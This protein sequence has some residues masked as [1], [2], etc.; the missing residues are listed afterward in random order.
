MK[1]EPDAHF[2]EFPQPVPYARAVAIQHALVEKR[3]A[4]EIPD[5]FLLLEHPPV[6]T[7]GRRGRRNFLLASEEQLLQEGIT[8]EPSERGGDVTWHGPGQ[9]VLYPI[10]KLGP[11]EM[12]THGY[13]HA[14]E[15][16]AIRTAA[17]FG[18]G[19][20]R[21][22]GMAGAWTE[23]GK[24]AAVGFKFRKWV[25]FHGLSINVRPDMRG[26]DLIVGCGLQ[27]ERVASFETVLGEGVP[28]MPAVAER[29]VEQV[30]QVF[31]RSLEVVQ[32][33][34]LSEDDALFH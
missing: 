2:Y 17:D 20:F 13:L 31:G 23:Q 15:E 34:D 18:I 27:G 26:F 9:W 1:A 22:D 12:G 29:I 30:S 5:T 4:D 33:L 32:A 19:A 25:S 24:F 7:L 21:R 3:I 28:A 14:L 8:V 11:A 16:V 10:L 6:I